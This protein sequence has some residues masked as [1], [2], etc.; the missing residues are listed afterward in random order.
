MRK[1][2]QAWDA[3]GVQQEGAVVV[4]VNRVDKASTFPFQSISQLTSAR[5]LE[6][7]IPESPRLLEVAT[8]ERDPRAITE[9]AWWR[10][11]T[12]IRNE[13]DNA[14]THGLGLEGK[15][16]RSASTKGRRGRRRE[17]EAGQIAVENVA[18][19]PM[20][21]FLS[22]IA[23][24]FV[25]VGISFLYSGHAAT[26]AAREFAIHNS[27]AQANVEA[28]KALPGPFRD[29][30]VV[31]RSGSDEI[32]VRVAIPGAGPAGIGFPQHVTSTR[33]VVMEP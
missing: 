16:G 32:S 33:S 14:G 21:F 9:I 18:M 22:L 20:A 24:Q 15:R 2:F 30:M 8:N 1:R 28:R 5:V 12:K 13:I 19:I 11:M 29:G 3:L 23:W 25:V 4:L 17:P 6:A 10:L 27:T 7:T 26:V 31:T